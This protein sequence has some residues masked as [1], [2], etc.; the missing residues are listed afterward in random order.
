M[1]AGQAG[2]EADAPVISPPRARPI[3]A[4][5][6]SLALHAALIALVQVSPPAST[7]PAPAIEARLVPSHAE[8]AASPSAGREATETVEP[9]PTPLVPAEIAEVLPAVATAEPPAA[10]PSIPTEAS[11]AAAPSEASAPSPGISLPVDLTY[12][13][14]RELDVQP[15]ARGRIEPAYP[16][17]ADRQQLSGRVR[18]QVKLEADG[19]VS[20]VEVVQADPPGVFEASAVE[21]FRAARFLPAQRGGRPVRALL[22]IE[23][24]YD[25]EGR[26]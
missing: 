21:A 23:V 8:T 11:P 24:E 6:I 14:A 5:W 25:W 12:Y 15:R 3:V 26:R 1:R 22:Q 9:L 7:G 10:P 4:I 16:E 13:T 20:D 19:R 17:A 2:F 18:L